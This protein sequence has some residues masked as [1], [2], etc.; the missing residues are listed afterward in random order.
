MLIQ[1]L[2]HEEIMAQGISWLS[3]AKQ[4]KP[5]RINQGPGERTRFLLF[6]ICFPLEAPLT[7]CPA[8]LGGAYVAAASHT[9]THRSTRTTHCHYQPLRGQVGA[10]W[11]EGQE[12]SKNL[13]F[14][15]RSCSVLCVFLEIQFK[16]LM[17]SKCLKMCHFEI[18]N[19]MVFSAFT[20]LCHHRHHLIRNI[21][22]PPPHNPISISG[23]P[24]FSTPPTPGNSP[25]AFSMDF[26]TLDFSSKENHTTCDLSMTGSSHSAS[27]FRGSFTS[28]RSQHV[29]PSTAEQYS[30]WMDHLLVIHSSADRP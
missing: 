30:T 10:A 15:V 12:D 3:S 1:K 27:C 7:L 26:P 23:L 25:S 5:S 19:S 6:L 28:S 4:D 8:R 22:M 24:P 18:H 16:Y 17:V 29:I 2:I 21:F 11:R 14:S 20:R 9:L 13:L